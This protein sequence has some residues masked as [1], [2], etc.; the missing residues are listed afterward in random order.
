M[1]KL[2]TWAVCGGILLGPV[3]RQ[4][5]PRFRAGV[6]IVAVDVT[7]LDKSGNPLADLTAA[8][9]SIEVDGRRRPVV[10]ATY[11]PAGRRSETAATSSPTSGSRPIDVA[12]MSVAAGMRSM[13]LAIDV[14]GIRSGAGRPAMESLAD[15]IDAI[16]AGDRVGLV[17]L[18]AGSPGVGLTTNRLA[19]RQ[20]LDRT[21]GVAPQARCEPTRGETAAHSAGDERGILAYIE[22]AGPQGLHCFRGERPTDPEPRRR[23]EM[24]IPVHRAEA[25]R[26]LASLAELARSLSQEPGRRAVVFVS[27]GLFGDDETRQ[28]LQEI[29]DVFE[30]NRVVLFGIHLD[31]PL[32]EASAATIRSGTRLMDDRYGFDAMAEAAV[33]AGGEAIRAIAHATPA[34]SRM[35][36]A[37][38]G[39]YLLAFERLPSD[40]DGK[41][42]R[43]KV[44]VA[45]RDVDLRFRRSVV[46]TPR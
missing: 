3:L 5:A 13:I 28:M 30:R 31:V 7:A 41:R 20:S 37:L 46:I 4:Q 22:R 44:Q 27:E 43:L 18:P 35:D 24:A 32:V 40:K 21:F 10:A 11:T 9:F 17:T 14:G 19:I 36:A 38:S 34:I 8:D 2:F 45:R 39:F 42:L 26:I 15:Y 12:P 25:A 33:A 16:P 6:E 29:A 23:L 1:L